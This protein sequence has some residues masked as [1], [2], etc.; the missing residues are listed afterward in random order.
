MTAKRGKA[1]ESHSRELTF[2]AW[3][4]RTQVK[5]VTEPGGE[6]EWVLRTEGITFYYH[7]RFRKGTPGRYKVDNQKCRRPYT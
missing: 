6:E 3:V 4:T 5:Q 7:L 2:V 1:T